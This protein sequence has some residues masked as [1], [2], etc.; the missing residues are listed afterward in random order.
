MRK[1]KRWIIGLVVVFLALCVG[2][3]RWSEQVPYRFLERRP[4][5]FAE[6]DSSGTYSEYYAFSDTATRVDELI[7]KEIAPN[8]S[9]FFGEYLP[10][11]MFHHRDYGPASLYSYD[12]Q[13]DYALWDPAMG[14]S[15]PKRRA[16]V[17]KGTRVIVGISREPS[18][19]DRLCAWMYRLRFD[20]LP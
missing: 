13:H 8:K 12:S 16:T 4:R 19:V 3:W 18:P 14:P 5:I 17:P 6:I 7:S 9:G 11:A 20:G 15:V 10:A 2:V 1:P